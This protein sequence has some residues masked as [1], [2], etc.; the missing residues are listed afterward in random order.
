MCKEHTHSG[1]KSV[2]ERGGGGGGHSLS[3]MQGP[4]RPLGVEPARERPRSQPRAEQKPPTPRVVSA[5]TDATSPDAL[6][7]SAGVPALPPIDP[8][9]AMEVAKR[10][11]RDGATRGPAPTPPKPPVRAPEPGIPSAP[12]KA[13][14]PEQAVKPQKPAAHAHVTIPGRI[15]QAATPEAKPALP[16]IKIQS[17]EAVLK[18]SLAWGNDFPQH[19]SRQAGQQ[20]VLRELSVAL[21]LGDP[22]LVEG[23]AKARLAYSLRMRVPKHLGHLMPEFLKSASPVQKGG[24]GKGGGK[25]R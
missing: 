21:G 24:K 19:G 22:G 13:P 5:K 15:P 11:L 3:S 1:T 20:H 8:A 17:V 6:D 10:G 4:S 12:V 7:T 25:R 2:S 16:P 23:E 9:S 14:P 18:E